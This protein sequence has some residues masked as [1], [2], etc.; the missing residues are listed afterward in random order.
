MAILAGMWFEQMHPGW[1]KALVA[2]R[3]LLEELELRL[4]D[5]TNLAPPTEKVMLAFQTDPDDVRVV[6]LGQDPYPGAGLAVGR[7]FAVGGHKLPGSLRNI[8]KE[9][10]SDLD[11]PPLSGMPDPDLHGWQSQGVMLLNRSLTTIENSAGAHTKIGWWQ[12]TEAALSHLLQNNIFTV[13]VLWGTHAQSIQTSLAAQISDAKNRV[14]IVTGAHPS[15]LSA[16]RGFFGSKPFSK[17]NAALIAAG[18]SP[19]D[20][21]C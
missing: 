3:A 11:P 1:Q 10:V 18:E 4:S 7:A 19:I 17:T 12:F 5:V 16:R 15:P 9:L 20:W 2:Q 14:A 21:S 6:I 8:F 13:L